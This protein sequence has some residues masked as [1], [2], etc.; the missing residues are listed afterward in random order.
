MS[1]TK[2]TKG[3]GT[4]SKTINDI[5]VYSEATGKD[6]ALFYK[7][8]RGINEEEAKANSRLAAAAP[9]LLE[10]L[11]NLV[12]LSYPTARPTKAEREHNFDKAIEAIKKA[13]T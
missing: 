9:E 5:A 3:P 11:Q 13:T 2:H 4:T 10:A 12:N 8:S 1:D 7:D 6:I